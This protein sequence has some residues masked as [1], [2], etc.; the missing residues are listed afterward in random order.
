M[1]KL[2]TLAGAAAL[3]VTGAAASAA[4]LDPDSY[5][6]GQDISNA[7]AG[8]TLTTVFA[9][10]GDPA[11]DILGT[12]A[13]FARNSGAVSTGGRGFAHSSN[14]VLWGN[15]SFEYLRVDFT[16]G[17]SSVSLDFINNDN[18]DNNAQLLAFD[19][20]GT[21]VDSELFA[22]N[23]NGPETLTVM[24]NISYVFAYWDQINRADN[25]A[26]DNLQYTAAV[27]LPAAMPLMLG[28][29]GAMAV[30]RRRR[31]SRQA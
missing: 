1:I 14:N 20:G 22:A 6:N 12:G 11:V 26:L 2:K 29:F 27:P 15:G 13:V 21:L 24:G 8:V 23:L 4:V 17:A 3:A 28:A 18:S 5:S 7:V 19:A 31:K 16:S 30:A 25:G 9:G 10:G